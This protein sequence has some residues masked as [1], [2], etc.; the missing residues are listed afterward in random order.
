MKLLRLS[1]S[2]LLLSFLS[3]STTT[4]TVWALTSNFP[5]EPQ[6]FDHLCDKSGG[7]RPLCKKHHVQVDVPASCV[8]DNGSDC[9]ILFYFHGAGGTNAW[10]SKLSN[11]HDHNF[12]GVYPQGEDGWNTG[13]KDTNSCDW[14]DFECT[15][16]PNETQFIYNII[17]GLRLEGASGNVYLIGSSDGA[18]LTYRVAVNALVT[19]GIK[20]IVAKVTQLLA[21]PERSGP[22]PHNYNVIMEKSFM[23][24][25]KISVLNIMGSDDKVIP[26]EGGSSSVFGSYDEF[27]L[28]NAYESIMAWSNHNGC[29]ETPIKSEFVTDYGTGVGTKYEFQNCLEGTRV[30]H[31]N[32]D[33]AGHDVGATIDRYDVYRNGATI[34]GEKVDY[35]IIYEFIHNLEDRT[36]SPPPAPTVPAPTP[37]GGACNDD[38]C[39]DET[40]AP[41]PTV[42]VPTP[43]TGGACKDDPNWYKKNNQTSKH[44]KSKRVFNCATV[45]QNPLRNCHWENDAGEKAQ[46]KCQLTCDPDCDAETDSSDDPDFDE[47]NECTDD[48][49]WAVK[50]NKEHNCDY[51]ALNPSMRC[52]WENSNGVAADQNCPVACNTC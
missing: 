37:T 38:D 42:L 19:Y 22:G 45:A 23:S 14:D 20:G 34:D 52:G 21:E 48:P 26:Y 2:S 15:T 6:F 17:D 5:Q 36:S 27:Q 11:V 51:V 24:T 50:F 33:G 44:G 7:D 8:V 31:Y 10:F 30:M 43:T 13:P 29:E 40:P 1:W 32:I 49:D 25:P 39:D 46:E 35:T 41:T 3:S 28:M 9:P 12:I 16:D 4:N 47:E 18:A